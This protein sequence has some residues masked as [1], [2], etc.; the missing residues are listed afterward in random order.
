MIKSELVRA[1]RNQVGAV[2][3]REVSDYVDFILDEITQALEDGD[4]VKITN[5]GR[6]ETYH[7][8]ARVGRN[9]KTLEETEI[10]A[11][12][13]VRFVM[14]EGVANVLNGNS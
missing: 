13:V 10:S 14:S 11:R 5:F 4:T 3:F 9:P 6:F 7:K 1:V 12:R 8:K 2:S